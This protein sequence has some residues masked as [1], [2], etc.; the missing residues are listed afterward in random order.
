MFE[1]TKSDAKKTF[2][3]MTN[4]I[5]DTVEERSTSLMNLIEK[6]EDLGA[7]NSSHEGDNEIKQEDQCISEMIK[8]Q[9][10]EIKFDQLVGMSDTLKSTVEYYSSV[11][12]TCTDVSMKTRCTKLIVS[13]LT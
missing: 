11:F 2:I 4:I 12:L 5:K 7:S 6:R 10:N 8:S 9:L 13:S 3:N 1:S